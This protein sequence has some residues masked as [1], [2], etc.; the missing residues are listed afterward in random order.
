M[1][2]IATRVMERYGVRH[3]FA[4]AAMAFAGE[5]LGLVIAVAGAGGIGA[6]GVGFMQADELRPVIRGPRTA[7][8]DVFNINFIIFF[9]NEEQRVV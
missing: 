2:S 9:G 8:G 3:P 5:K 4:Q 1:A 6:I 7:T